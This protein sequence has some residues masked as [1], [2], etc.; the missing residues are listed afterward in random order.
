MDYDSKKKTH[1]NFKCFF[2]RFQTFKS[3]I[4]FI[5]QH[6]AEA[7]AGKQLYTVKLNEFADSTASEFFMLINGVD[8]NS[9]QVQNSI[10]SYLNKPDPRNYTLHFA[11]SLG[12][13]KAAT[14]GMKH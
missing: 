12:K 1:S 6:N 7:K 11:R 14:V 8:P 13:R 9:K 3:N 5:A 2:L 4:A 10:G